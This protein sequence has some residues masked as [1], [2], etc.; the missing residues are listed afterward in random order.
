VVID[1]ALLKRLVSYETEFTH[2]N[3]D[4]IA[5][6]SGNLLGV[7]KV[8]FKPSDWANWFDDVLK[9][10]DTDLRQA[11][12]SLPT[13]NK[14]FVVSSDVMNI[15]CMWLIHAFYNSNLSKED[16]HLGM[17]SAALVFHYK[18]L[19]SKLAHDFPFPA[20]REVATA[21]YAALSKKY[22]LKQYG[23]WG[24][25]LRARCED[26]IA[27]RQLHWKTIQT[28]SPDAKVLYMVTDTQGRI[29][30]VVKKL[31][32]VLEK[33]RSSDA[34]IISTSGTV[35]VDGETKV[36]DL[37]RHLISYKHYIQGII[38]TESSFIKEELIEVTA[39]TMHTM[40][41][42]HLTTVLHW[43]A[44]NVTSS[45]YGNDIEKL[46]DETMVH[47]F[48]VLS[49]DA[50]KYHRAFDLPF[51]ISKLRGIYMS[52]RST[53][54]YLLALRALADKLIRIPLNGK[55]ASAQA[56]VRTGLL[57][58]IVLRALTRNY[59]TTQST[60]GHRPSPLAA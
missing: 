57:I 18:V 8:R 50:H 28:F 22:A 60:L 37:T 47:A 27:E 17:L 39:N 44:K 16:K 36:G 55:S 20:N 53:D 4:H 7:D 32:E 23:S 14:D 49:E 34:K 41:P 12:H 30:D 13:V 58:Y 51:V 6:F 35:T 40:N 2:R 21:V 31:W 19:S 59:Y 45:Q 56:S 46:I 11:I 24:A 29:R 3:A 1:K 48:G 26:L 33:V 38:S 43:I 10:D 52:S 25:L 54:E 15:S 5:F 42:D 9:I